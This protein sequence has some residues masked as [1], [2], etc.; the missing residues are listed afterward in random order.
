M[1]FDR[2]QRYS[3]LLEKRIAQL[4]AIVDAGSKTFPG[5]SVG[6]DNNRTG[7]AQIR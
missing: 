2:Q 4:E 3:E 6:E 1:D 5:V 7:A